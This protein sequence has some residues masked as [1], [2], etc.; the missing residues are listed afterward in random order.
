VKGPRKNDPANEPVS[1]MEELKR[2]GSRQP[3]MHKLKRSSGEKA[4][5]QTKLAG[6]CR[7]LYTK[8]V[9]GGP[10]AGKVTPNREGEKETPLGDSTEETGKKQR[11][12][13]PGLFHSWGGGWVG[14]NLRKGP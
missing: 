5:Q 14:K 2:G 8:R 4:A 1:E 13:Q 9:Y 6:V 10:L 11:K 3:V 12:G 7:Y